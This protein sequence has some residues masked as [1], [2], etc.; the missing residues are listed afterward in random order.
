M[1][2]TTK[3]KIHFMMHTQFYH[4]KLLGPLFRRMGVIEVPRPGPKK[5]QEFMEKTRQ[6]LRDGELICMF[7]EGGV[8][9]N[10]LILRFKSFVPRGYSVITPPWLSIR[11]AISLW[12]EG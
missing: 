6:L 4:M 9:G 8:S 1:M 11:T 5:M 10:G 2:A 7:P 12:T 3:R